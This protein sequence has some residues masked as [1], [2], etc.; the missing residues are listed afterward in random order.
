MFSVLLPI[1]YV[2]A[3]V[4]PQQPPCAL[5]AGVSA[6]GDGDG[7]GDPCC[8]KRC[9]A[10][11]DVEEMVLWRPGDPLPFSHAFGVSEEQTDTAAKAA[12]AEA[13]DDVETLAAIAAVV[14]V[15]APPTPAPN[16]AGAEAPEPADAATD[17]P[18]PAPPLPKPP[19]APRVKIPPAAYNGVTALVDDPN[20]A[21]APFYASL[22]RTALKDGKTRVSHWGDS[23]IAAD[24][25]THMA[26]R[27]LQTAFGDGGH[28][29][30]MVD[31]GT[32][33]YLQ[34]D[35]R[36]HSKG[37]KTANVIKKQARDG[38]YGY[39]GV[40]SRGYTGAKATYGTSDKGPVGGK[41]SQFQ[42]YHAKMPKQGELE[43]RLDGGEPTMV[44]M[45]ADVLTDAVHVVE[46]PDGPHELRIRA[47][48]GG[49]RLY[50]VALERDVPGV[51]YDGIGMV[52]A[53][54][55]RLLNA[56]PDHWKRQ[57]S[58]RAPDLI[59]LMFGGNSLADRTSIKRYEQGYRDAVKRF[60]TSRPEAACLLI[61]PVDHGVKIRR[62]ARTPERLIEM[63]E[64]QRRVAHTEGCAYW[65]AFDAMGGRDAMASWV[66][67]GLAEGDYAH[68]TRQGSMVLGELYFKALMKGFAEWLGTPKSAE[69]TAPQGA[70]P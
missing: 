44:P 69:A 1:P 21:M 8:G 22:E 34:K 60:R 16:P 66:D 57:L 36:W 26:R 55:R 18:E 11:M 51:V 33:W 54:L 5:Q 67:K 42:I 19:P 56:D 53:R 12:R 4:V 63:I 48:G 9:I 58:L 25:L 50:G 65:S 28:G 37:W 46:V 64:A 10:G 31:S 15:Q 39:G 6:D 68:L 35:V 38:H 45:T 61:S 2:L 23:V 17:S 40:S 49:V 43:L 62:R 3:E 52:G 59:V 20:G 41:V 24:G 13:L 14:V 70:L 27:L 47:M 29:F 7:D 32:E 30:V